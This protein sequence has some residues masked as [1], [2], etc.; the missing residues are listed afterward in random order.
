MFPTLCIA[1]VSGMCVATANAPRAFVTLPA[2]RVPG[3]AVREPEALARFAW[4]GMDDDAQRLAQHRHHGRRRRGGGGGDDAAPTT[5]PAAQ[6]SAAPAAPTPMGDP[7]PVQRPTTIEPEPEAVQSA[8]ASPAP[9]ASEASAAP[10]EATEPATEGAAA[11]EEEPSI[12]LIR[13]RE[14]MTRMHRALGISTVVSLA[15][16]EVAGTFLAINRP[17]LF[18][19]GACAGGAMGGSGNC[20]FGQFGE[21]G[22]G[23]VHEA[24][25]F[26]TVAFYAST[27]IYA[28]SMPDPEHASA[29]NDARSG[30]LRWHRRMAWVHFIGMVLQPLLGIVSLHPELVGVP[31]TGTSIADA[32]AAL[33]TVHLG[34]G[35]VTLAALATGMTIEL[36]Q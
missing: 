29:G 1:F 30:R 7:Q 35:Y 14:R 12:D 21:G 36:L 3:V 15:L 31:N 20:V 22:L 25:A 27:G 4:P 23:V 16:T 13:Q 6:P 10:S 17:T 19:P 9:E 18:G 24:S 34:V 33:R 5:G 8:E 26:V 11:E 2:L 28:L 32:Q